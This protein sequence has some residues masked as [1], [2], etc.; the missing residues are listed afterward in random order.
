MVLEAQDVSFA[1]GPTKWAIRNLTV[2][3]DSP[4]RVALLGANGV[5]KSTFMMLING[6]LRPQEGQMRVLGKPIDYSRSGLKA[7][8]R[9]VGIVL[10]DP[11]DQLF[12][13][14][15]EQDVAFGPLNNGMEPPTVRKLVSDT[16]LR[17][18]IPYLAD[19]PIHEL[20]LGE[21]KRVALAGILVL[22][23]SIILLDEPTAGL[24]FAGI[25]AMLDLL[26]DL[27]RAGTTLIVS[28]HDTD[29]AYEWADD[30]WILLN[31]TLAAQGPI[32]DV[33]RNEVL[34]DAH[35]RVPAM[36][37]LGSALQEAYPKLASQPLPRNRDEMLA[38]IRKSRPEVPAD[39]APLAAR[40]ISNPVRA[41]SA[42]SFCPTPGGLVAPGVPKI[43]TS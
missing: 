40:T 36:V 4:R 15:V 14:T 20:S 41:T 3:L 6:T 32:T 2:G 19:R 21:K 37:Q 5:G 35:L 11:D 34:A 26:D 10:Q 1:Y 24:D 17:M 9:Q 42:A 38:M 12:G 16:L 33:V 28:T 43:A 25:T 18:G 30:A 27:H 39:T 13:A 31:G 22:R 7:L 23:P 29:L 8:R